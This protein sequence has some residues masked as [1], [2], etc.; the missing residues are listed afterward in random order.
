MM[1]NEEADKLAGRGE[2]GHLCWLIFLELLDFF[3]LISF[4]PIGVII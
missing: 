4:M 3:G 1:M 2:T